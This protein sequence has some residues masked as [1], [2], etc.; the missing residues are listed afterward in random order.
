M[1]PWI[2]TKAWDE[3]TNLIDLKE[4]NGT[5]KRTSYVQWLNFNHQHYSSILQD[6][7]PMHFYP[8]ALVPAMHLINELWRKWNACQVLICLFCQHRDNS[9]AFIIARLLRKIATVSTYRAL[10]K[11]AFP[12]V[13]IFWRVFVSFIHLFVKVVTID[14]PT[15]NTTLICGLCI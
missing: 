9:F 2:L 5:T 7:E 13:M 14:C 10:L 1:Y 11:I 15:L 6:L 12:S 3:I 4:E 8:E